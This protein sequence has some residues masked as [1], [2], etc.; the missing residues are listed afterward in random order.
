METKAFVPYQRLCHVF[1]RQRFNFCS[2]MKLR[3]RVNFEAFLH[4]RSKPLEIQSLLNLTSYIIQ[5]C[6]WPYLQSYQRE[7]SYVSDEIIISVMVK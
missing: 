5:D 4:G 6:N 3:R 1:D 7:R 2:Q